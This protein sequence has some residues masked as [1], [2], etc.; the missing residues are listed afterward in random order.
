MLL[1]Y[2]SSQCQTG[3]YQAWLSEPFILHENAEN[4]LTRKEVFLAAEQFRKLLFDKSHNSNF[5]LLLLYQQRHHFLIALL[6]IAMQKGRVVL[7]P[8]LADK[9]LSNLKVDM[10]DL[11]VLSNDLPDSLEGQNQIQSIEIDKIIQGVKHSN[12][13]I[14]DQWLSDTLESIQ[15]SEIWLY[16]SG[17][18]GLPKKVIKTWRNMMGSAELAIERFT[19]M[20]PCYM[21]TTVPSQH[22]FGLETSIFWPLFSRASIWFNKPMFP[23]EV[24]HALN[25]NNEQ[26]SFLVST[27]LHIKNLVSSSAEW[28]NNLTRLLSATAPLT[29]ELAVQTECVMN[30]SV[31]EVYGSTE[32]ASIAS[33]QTTQTDVWQSYSGVEFTKT[34]DGDVLV[35]TKGLDSFQALNDQIEHLDEIRFR[36]GK[37]STDLVKVAGKRASLSEINAHLQAISGI[38]EGVFIQCK[39]SERLAVFVVSKLPKSAILAELRKS[40]DPTFLPRS[41][42]YIPRLPRNELGK[43]LYSDL[44]EMLPR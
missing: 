13:E 36:L 10:P 44:F 32:T 43:V 42:F 7:P 12:I 35:K 30:V 18:T 9:T 21:V 1:P 39:T 20:K 19:L 14:N 27:P 24:V 6:A 40:I 15:D 8:N 31:F 33:R 5:S 26:P 38:V 22:M 23:E 4:G 37:R 11:I 41:I 29:K 3:L 16:T 2:L 17:S 28:P 25:A 34:Q